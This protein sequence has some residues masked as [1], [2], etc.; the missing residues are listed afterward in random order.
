MLGAIIGDIIESYY[1]VLEINAKKNSPD[2]KRQY[3]E[4]ISIL[5][6]DIALFNSECSYTDDSVLTLA[7][8][9]TLLSDKDYESSLRKY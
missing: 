6:K 1:E 8:A 9:S 2:K 3:E 7:I 5:N 4:R